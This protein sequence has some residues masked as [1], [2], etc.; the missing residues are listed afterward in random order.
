MSLEYSWGSAGF[1]EKG[2]KGTFVWGGPASCH[3]NGPGAALQDVWT[4][5]PGGVFVGWR[6]PGPAPA[7]CMLKS[8]HQGKSDAPQTHTHT[9][10]QKH[11]HKHKHE[12]KHKHKHFFVRPELLKAPKTLGNIE[13]SAPTSLGESHEGLASGRSS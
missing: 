10:T 12:H 8:W 9:H 4:R 5:A 11:K 3:D 13:I 2:K 6:P 1:G 7:P